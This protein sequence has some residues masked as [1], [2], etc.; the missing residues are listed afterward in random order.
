MSA[1]S[2]VPSRRFVSPRPSARPRVFLAAG[3]AFVSIGLVAAI[4][5]A[6]QAPGRP[7]PSSLEQPSI[8]WPHRP[9][10][11][12]IALPR[13]FT[14][15]VL[16]PGGDPGPVVTPTGTEGAPDTAPTVALFLLAAAVVTV[17]LGA[18]E[19]LPKRRTH[20]PRRAAATTERRSPPPGGGE[21]AGQLV[22]PASSALLGS[23]PAGRAR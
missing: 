2:S 20:A 6:G 11:A 14:D 17:A 23:E 7:A 10:L 8:V 13:P 16:G 15:R 1:I 3:L 4:L 12:M 19:L 18:I 22:R 5:L 21:Q 9:V